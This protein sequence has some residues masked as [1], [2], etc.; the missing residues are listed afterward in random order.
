M[1]RS[2]PSQRVAHGARD[3][4]SRAFGGGAGAPVTP[5]Q[6]Q[7]RS[8]PAPRGAE[9]DGAG[10]SAATLSRA[11]APDVRGRREWTRRHGRRR[12][13]LGALDISLPESNAAKLGQRPRQLPPQV[14]AKLL[15]GEQ[16]FLLGFRVGPSQSENLGAVDAAAAMETSHRLPLVPAFHRFGPLIGEVVLPKGLQGTHEFA[17]HDACR[18]RIDRSRPKPWPRPLR[19]GARGPA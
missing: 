7:S 9:R 18:E 19:S 16:G 17:V 4:T 3:G 8:P 15:A 11:R 13:L 1:M 2:D 12:R 6:R 14:G 10:Y 5:P